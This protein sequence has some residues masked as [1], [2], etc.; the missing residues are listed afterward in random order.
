MAE[1]SWVGKGLGVIGNVAREVLVNGGWGKGRE[2]E[3]G[4]GWEYYSW[5]EEVI[6]LG[7]YI[8]SCR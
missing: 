4:E 8:C 5:E 1:S 7:R 3:K 6:L 2:K